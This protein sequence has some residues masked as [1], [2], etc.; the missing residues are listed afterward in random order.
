MS[1]KLSQPHS[2]NLE[3]FWRFSVSCPEKLGK[4]FISVDYSLNNWRMIR[5]DKFLMVKFEKSIKATHILQLRCFQIQEFMNE[6][7]LVEI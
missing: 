7:T 5:E 2:F 3:S 4:K 1:I 6:H